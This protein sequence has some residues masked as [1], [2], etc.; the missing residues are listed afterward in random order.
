MR[1]HMCEHRSSWVHEP[2]TH[3][4][5]HTPLPLSHYPHTSLYSRSVATSPSEPANPS[6]LAAES[7]EGN[8]WT[9][10]VCVLD[11]GGDGD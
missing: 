2:R 3:T 4:H 11:L 1:E 9:R 5:T 8:S 7:A 10:P 6:P